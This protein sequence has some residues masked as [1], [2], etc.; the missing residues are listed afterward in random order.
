[1]PAKEESSNEIA[2][3]GDGL[4]T[5]NTE[6]P[7]LLTAYFERIGRKKLLTPR[8][9]VDLGRRVRTGDGQARRELIEKNLKL[10]ISVAKKYRG[11]GLPFDD[12]IQEGNIGLMR[13]VEKFDPDRGYRFSTYA[14]WWIWQAVTRAVM[15]QGRTIRVPVHVAEKVRRVNR[16]CNKLAVSHGREP[17]EEEV[18]DG[19]GW[20]VDEVRL[21]LGVV[22]D[23]VS[24]SSPVGEEDAASS[25]LE[26]LVE[27]EEGSDTPGEVIRAIET[28]LFK[29]AVE[30]LP[31]KARYVLLRR[32]GLDDREPATL[33][34]LGEE[35]GMSRESVRQLQTQAERILKASGYVRSY[36]EIWK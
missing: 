10:V 26:D 35:L 21:I 29:E 31:E 4:L 18:A 11:R 27:D 20:D 13:A 25:E 14:T 12:L 3:N 1:L 32:Y 19:L 16:V 24:L 8:E 7:E 28:E 5:Q 30:R 36:R 23:P 2:T 34:E 17:S 15:D 22:P 33:P 6:T 9:E